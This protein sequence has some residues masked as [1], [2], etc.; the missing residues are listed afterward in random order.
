MPW[1]VSRPQVQ[2]PTPVERARWVNCGM[3]L[4]WSLVTTQDGMVRIPFRSYDRS[5]VV[6]VLVACCPAEFQVRRATGIVRN[7]RR[8]ADRLDECDN[9]N[10]FAAIAVGMLSAVIVPG[11]FY[12]VASIWKAIK[13]QHEKRQAI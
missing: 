1:A 12:I 4:S 11:S 2:R 13:F 8:D 5:V 10:K 3:F 9:R 7:G 6:V